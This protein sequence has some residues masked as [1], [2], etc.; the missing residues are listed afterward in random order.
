[1]EKTSD[2]K[3]G[4][5][6]FVKIGGVAAL[7]LAAV[8]GLPS[9]ILAQGKGKSPRWGFLID[10]RRCVGCKACSVACKTEFDTRL[11]YFRSSVKELEKGT[12]PDTS[13]GFVPWLCNHC[14][15]PVCVED[16]PV[17][18]VDASFTFP[19]GET[20]TYRKH[21]TY[22]RPDGAVLIDQHRCVGCGACVRGCPYD[23][24]Y[25]DESKK[26]GGD[27]NEHPADKCTL[28]VHRLDEGI[29]PSCVNTCQGHARMVG[30]L[31]DPE[32]E[33]SVTLKANKTAV[34]LPEEKTGPQCFYIDLD[35]DVY[36]SGRDTKDE[37]EQA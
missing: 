6:E 1:M 36:K 23:V 10:L 35:P 13:R 19:D 7:A 32:S 31:N 27:P 12:Y 37:A 2:K 28:C 24:R 15:N 30:D 29:V 21:A 33:I 3:S 14:E 9:K 5:R 18:E 11:G 20:V 26:A 17:D 22:K 34:L 25:L 4:R 16:C 8:S